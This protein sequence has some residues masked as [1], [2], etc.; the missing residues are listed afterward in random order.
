MHGVRLKLKSMRTFYS[1]I[2]YY[3][4]CGYFYIVQQMA[5]KIW[6]FLLVMSL[7]AAERGRGFGSLAAVS[8]N[9]DYQQIQQ[10]LF[11]FDDKRSKSKSSSKLEKNKK[12][13][14]RGNI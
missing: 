14:L 5:L 7:P 2:I 1:T 4:L 8:G 12:I 3:C 10:K 13:K 6:T 11:S 9:I